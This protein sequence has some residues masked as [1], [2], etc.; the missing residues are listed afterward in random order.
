MARGQLPHL[1]QPIEPKLSLKEHYEFEPAIEHMDSL[2]FIAA[3]MIDN[4]AAR[5]TER[6]LVLASLEASLHLGKRV[7]TLVIRPALPTID[8]KF[9]LKLLQIEL[10]SHPPPAA[11]TA[12]SIEA[13]AGHGSKVQLGLFSPQLPEPS[14]LDVTLARLKAIVGD[15]RVGSPVLEDT[16]NSHGHHIEAFCLTDSSKKEYIHHP[17]MALRRMR[18]PHPVQV[19][20]AGQQ[21]VA[22]HDGHRLYSIFAA[23]GPWKTSG[24]WWGT[25]GVGSR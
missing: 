17:R 16:H 20:C 2:L 4:L 25:R 8:R 13:H 21:P 22:F 15:D 6:A 1:F 3:R 19:R 7:H 9:L 18:P 12:L 24:S 11:V 5:A 23:Y 14:R 10:S